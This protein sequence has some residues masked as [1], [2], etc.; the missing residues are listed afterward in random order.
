MVEGG[1]NCGA[2]RYRIAGETG[3]VAQ[4]H[5]RNCQRQTGSA[6]SFNLVLASDS[7]EITG[8]PAIYR[9]T[10]TSSGNPVDRMFCSNCGSQIFSRPSL[11][12]G[13]LIVKAGTLDDPTPFVPAV[14]LWTS[15]RLPWVDIPAGVASYPK[16]PG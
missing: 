12:K 3:V 1:C 7:V 9:D 8:T 15:S 2:I 4:C 6:F 11:D 14:S 16:N 5:C 10:D 13:R